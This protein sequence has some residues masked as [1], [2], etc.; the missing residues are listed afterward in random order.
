MNRHFVNSPILAR[1]RN[2]SAGT[3]CVPLPC[4]LLHPG[5]KA[6]SE[7][8]AVKDGALRFLLQQGRASA[9]GLRA[10][11]EEH[12]APLPDAKAG[13]KL[14]RPLVRVKDLK[15]VPVDDEIQVSRRLRIVSRLSISRFAQPCARFLSRK[16]LTISETKVRVSTCFCVH[17]RLLRHSSK[18][19]PPC[20]SAPS[21]M[22]HWRTEH[23][24]RRSISPRAGPGSSEVSRQ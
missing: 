6:P 15:A 19:R 22:A 10:T 5:R 14:P 13:H 11:E 16:A 2:R 18:P 24:P 4:E 1:G 7:Q 3:P 17:R 8:G 9:T 23:T 21:W 12:V 20:S